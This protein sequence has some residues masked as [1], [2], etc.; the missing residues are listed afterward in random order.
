M[1]L[2]SVHGWTVS[3]GGNHAI[4]TLEVLYSGRQQRCPQGNSRPIIS[5][6]I[7]QQRQ[8]P[9]ERGPC[10]EADAAEKVTPIKAEFRH[11]FGERR[12]TQKMHH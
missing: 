5:N 12:V 11:F 2:G 7:A 8:Q 1:V 3:G 4:T 9:L 6:V 10:H